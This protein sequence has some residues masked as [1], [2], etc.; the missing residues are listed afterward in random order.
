MKLSLPGRQLDLQR[1]STLVVSKALGV[2]VVCVSGSIWLSDRRLGTDHLL[3]TGESRRIRSNGR[4]VLSTF[5]ASSLRLLDPSEAP[6]PVG[7]ASSLLVAGRGAG[8][9]SGGRLQ[10][11]D[12]P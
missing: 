12:A 2:E 9:R 7:G 3:R 4:V 6:A 5:E 11:G 1:C 8:L 10:A